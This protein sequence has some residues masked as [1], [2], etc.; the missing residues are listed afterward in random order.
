MVSILNGGSIHVCTLLAG[1]FKI[2]FVCW[3]HEAMTA[4]RARP[5]RAH[6]AL[7]ELSAAPAAARSSRASVLAQADSARSASSHLTINPRL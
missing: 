2:K 7:Q 1:K 4:I 3:R 6:P 5:L